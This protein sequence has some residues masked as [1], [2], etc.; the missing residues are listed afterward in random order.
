MGVKLRTQATTDA[1]N[2]VAE[3]LDGAH[4]ARFR[5]SP[6]RADE[7][8]DNFVVARFPPVV[9]KYPAILP[10]ERVTHIVPQQSTAVLSLT[11]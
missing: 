3:R 8:D 9:V 2:A 6:Y 7:K 4:F 1:D 11:M 10:G 5:K